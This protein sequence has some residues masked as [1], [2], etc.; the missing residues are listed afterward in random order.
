MVLNSNREYLILGQHGI[1]LLIRRLQETIIQ[2]IHTLDSKTNNQNKE[3]L[4]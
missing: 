4:F 2:S 1:Y 3:L